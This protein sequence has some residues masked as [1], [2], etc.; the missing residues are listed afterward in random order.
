[1]KVEYINPFIVAARNVF[2]TMIHV[3]LTLGKPFLKEQD[4]RTYRVAALVGLS[5]TIE[6]IV[7]MRFSHPVALALASGL[8]KGE[9]KAI[10]ADCLD[11]LGEIGNMIVGNAKKDFPGGLVKISVPKVVT[12]DKQIHYP[13]NT[14][15]IV[16]PCDTGPGRFVIE[17]SFKMQDTPDAKPTTAAA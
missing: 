1:M 3:P 13:A 14:P 12:D 7:V 5:G 9:V 10:D 6:G 16:I 15:V 11:A 4:Q 2:D 17:V 8:I